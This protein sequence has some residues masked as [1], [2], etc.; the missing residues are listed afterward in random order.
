MLMMKTKKVYEESSGKVICQKRRK[1]PA[2]STV[3]ASINSFGML[4]SPARNRIM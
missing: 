4:L 2:P 1:F 3:A